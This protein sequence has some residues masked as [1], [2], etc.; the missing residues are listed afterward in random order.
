MARVSSARLVFWPANSRSVRLFY[1]PRSLW[2]IRSVSEKQP[3][4]Y[5]PPED[6]TAGLKAF[7]D[8]RPKS[9][10]IRLLLSGGRGGYR[11]VLD[12]APTFA[13]VMDPDD[14]RPEADDVII[15]LGERENGSEFPPCNFRDAASELWSEALRIFLESKR[16]GTEQFWRQGRMRLQVLD[17]TRE[18]VKVEPQVLD[19]AALGETDDV[20]ARPSSGGDEFRVISDHSRAITKELREFAAQQATLLRT[21]NEAVLSGAAKAIELMKEASDYKAQS[22][23]AIAEAAGQG[24]FWNTDAGQVVVARAVET[25]PTVINGAIE[26]ATGWMK[27]QL[28]KAEAEA[29][30]RASKPE[31]EPEP[32]TRRRKRTKG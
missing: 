16:G 25:L 5:E 13:A 22:A 18:L 24:S 9:P 10:V 4:I 19:R 31:P 6:W 23:L 8:A 32:K 1:W 14:T 30:G 26:L 20:H 28:A 15:E 12:L 17:G 11:A 29:R 2:H 7:V 27:L 21:G 3:T